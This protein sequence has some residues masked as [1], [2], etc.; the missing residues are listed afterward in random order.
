MKTL[1]TLVEDVYS[2]LEDGKEASDEHLDILSNNIRNLLRDRLKAP[3]E[4]RT[5]TLRM[6]AIGKPLRQIWYDHNPDGTEETFDGKTLLKFLYGDIIEEM[7][8]YLAREAGHTVEDQ[9]KEVE[10]DGVKGHIDAKIDGTLVDV[11]STSKFAFAKFRDGTLRQDDAFGY[12]GQLSGYAEAEGGG[13]AAFWA[14]SKETGDLA[15]LSVSADEVEFEQPRDL[16]RR[17]KEAVSSDTPPSRCY[18]AVPHGKKG[19]MKLPPGCSYCKHK[20]RCW[21]DSNDNK[22]LRTFIYSNGP[23]FMTEVKDPPRVYEKE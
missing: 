7:L 19:N 13:D 5:P 11:K 23:V 1:D 16:I 14:M 20:F 18:D 9:Q 12:M 10:L 4:P 3:L 6:S 2:L 22:G 15:L 8:L 21:A 17:Q